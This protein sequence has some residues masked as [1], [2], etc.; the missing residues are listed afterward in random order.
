MSNNI[1]RLE[2]AYSELIPVLI[3]EVDKNPKV[4]ALDRNKEY[5]S[6]VVLKNW[7]SMKYLTGKFDSKLSKEGFCGL[8]HFKKD[9]GSRRKRELYIEMFGK[10]VESMQT[11]FEFLALYP[12]HKKWILK[13][14]IWSIIST[15]NT[16]VV[17]IA[18]K[19]WII[20]IEQI[21]LKSERKYK[22]EVNLKYLKVITCQKVYIILAE[23]VVQRKCD[24]EDNESCQLFCENPADEL[25]KGFL[26]AD[27]LANYGKR[28]P[29][30]ASWFFSKGK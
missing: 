2:N 4:I 10:L 11:T 26:I 24:P 16:S 18:D 1:K 28:M 29:E 23:D 8:E 7:N 12:S 20:P 30:K 27:N 21:V 3:H 22:Y 14:D 9:K 13:N 6:I 25:Y 19:N 15:L 5:L 17:I